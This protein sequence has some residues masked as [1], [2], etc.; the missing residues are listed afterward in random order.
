MAR[1]RV[2]DPGL[3]LDERLEAFVDNRLDLYAFLEPYVLALRLREP[4]SPVLRE[5]RR[6]LMS[7]SRHEIGTTFATELAAD[8]DAEDPED[9]L[10]GIETCI[11]WPAWFHL[12]AELGL[13]PADVR[14]VL[15][16]SLRHLVA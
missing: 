9:A 13:A 4:S 11:S 5:R 15:C 8:Q 7:A 1:V 6:L 12:H 14:R 16:R 3:P 10:L 2:I